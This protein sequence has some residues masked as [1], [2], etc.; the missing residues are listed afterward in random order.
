MPAE[1]AQQLLACAA[2]LL[3]AAIFRRLSSEMR[4]AIFVIV[5]GTGVLAIIAGAA[6]NAIW[7]IFD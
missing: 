3:A 5:F 2:L 6:H 4:C 1:Y 7:R